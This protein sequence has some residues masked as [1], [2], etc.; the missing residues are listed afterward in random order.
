MSSKVSAV[1]RR[2]IRKA[3]TE[4]DLDF[5]LTDSALDG[6]VRALRKVLNEQTPANVAEES[7]LLVAALR[8]WIELCIPQVTDEWDNEV[9]SN[10]LW[11]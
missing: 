8:P 1:A 4:I 10:F 3:L 9:L 6:F 11:E 5:H 7:Q 2:R